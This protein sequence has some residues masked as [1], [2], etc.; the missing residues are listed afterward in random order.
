MIEKKYTLE[1]IT[2]AWYK[3]YGEHMKD[4]YEGFILFLKNKK[5]ED[6]KKTT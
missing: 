2:G 6:E 5:E 4:E 1:E 3:C